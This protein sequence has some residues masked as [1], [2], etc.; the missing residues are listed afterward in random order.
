M[1]RETAIAQAARLK[2]TA[3]G[4]TAGF[5]ACLVLSV[6]AATAGL[7]VLFVPLGLETSH[8]QVIGIPVIMGALPILVLGLILKALSNR[9]SDRVTLLSI[10]Y[11]F[12]VHELL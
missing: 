9:V 6:G 7:I 10:E 1:K 2:R 3:G 5:V 11:D 8:A 12:E 4:L